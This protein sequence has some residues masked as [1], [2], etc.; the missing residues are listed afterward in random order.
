MGCAGQVIFPGLVKDVRSVLAACDVGFVLSYKESASYAC[1]ESLALGL[2]V[3]ISNAG[4]LPES[5]EHLHE[6]WVVPSG[7]VDAI[8]AHLREMLCQK[9]CLKTVGQRARVRA[10]MRFD[11]QRFSLDTYQ[12]YLKARAL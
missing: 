2:P 12:A 10:E 11:A 9:Y 8:E 6:G 7:D 1:Y 4:G 3:L 5:I